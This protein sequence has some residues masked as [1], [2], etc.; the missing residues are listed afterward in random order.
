M[1]HQ[2]KKGV[3]KQVS[4]HERAIIFALNRYECFIEEGEPYN[5]EYDEAV[6]DLLE[7]LVINSYNHHSQKHIDELMDLLGL[8]NLKE[9]KL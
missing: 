3:K 6:Q 4:I 7:Y 9:T 5:F 1:E 2:L 8:W